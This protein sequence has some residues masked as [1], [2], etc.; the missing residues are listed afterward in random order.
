MK[1]RCT[2]EG[3]GAALLLLFYYRGLIEP[4]N[5]A[6]FYHGLPAAHLIGGYLVDLLGIAILLSLLLFALQYVPPV[7]QKTAQAMF[8]GLMVWRIL[9]L[10]V[11]LQTSNWLSAC[12]L[13]M[14]KQSL[15]GIL[16][17]LC[18]GVH[19]VPRITLPVIRVVHLCVAAT[20]FSALWVIPQLIHVALVRPPDKQ[21]ASA[22]PPTMTYKEADQRIIWI[23]F[24]ELSYDQT[25]DHP[26]PGVELPH[27]RRLRSESVSYSKLTP[28]GFHTQEIIPSL[29]SGTRIV[30]IR[31]T[32]GGDFQY[33]DES[34]NRWLAYDPQDTLFGLAHSRGWSSGVDEWTFPFCRILAS[35]LDSCSWEPSVLL[36]TELYGASEGKPVLA[37]AAVLPRM[38]LD[39]GASRSDSAWETNSRDYRDILGH[40]EALIGESQMRFV[41]LHFPV[42]HPPGIYD[43]RSH[44]LRRGGTYLDNLV[45]ADDTLGLL[46]QEID[47]TPSSH[48]TTV[49]VSSDHSWRISLYRHGAGWSAEEERACGGHFDDR[50]VLLIHFP[51]QK[52][53]VDVSAAVPELLEH[54]MIAGMLRGEIASPGDL[55]QLENKRAGAH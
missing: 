52:A 50:P 10:A 38:L 13:G 34:R 8:A 53:A 2:L 27:F 32:V 36:P 3:V 37:N 26:F 44:L 21:S 54:D 35:V 20:A 30:G 7:P 45:L 23:L 4:S 5:L 19:L 12:W 16:L 51:E 55:N 24:D 39:V 48:R 49:I 15:V 40:A 14:R 33:E 9:D 47:A 29:F 1:L 11:A 41:F 18:I 28:A 42:P 25:F 31:S 22:H 6:L 43:R 17:A 46:L